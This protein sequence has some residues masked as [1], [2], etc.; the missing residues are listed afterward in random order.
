[1][2][3]YIRKSLSFGPIRFNLSN[4][5][6]GVSAGIKGFRVGSGPR[7]NYVHVGR[8]GLYYRASLPS[9]VPSSRVQPSSVPSAGNLPLMLD[10][11]SASV[12]QIVDVSSQAIVSELRDKQ[13]R[14]RLSPWIVAIGL[15][16]TLMLGANNNPKAGIA[17]AALFIAAFILAH[18]FDANRKTTVI[19]Y[20][21]EDQTGGTFKS[22]HDAFETLG[23]A[24]RLWHIPSKGGVRDAKY[25]AGANELVSRN[26]ISV[27]FDNPKFVR[28]NI[29]TPNFSVGSQRLYFFPDR[30]FI[31][32]G[33][34]IGALVYESVRTDVQPTGFI[35]TES[36]PSDS[37]KIGQ[38]WRYVN[39]KGG[40][41]RRFKDNPELPIMQ[42]EQL[43]LRSN[44]GLNELLMV[45]R[46]GT[47]NAVVVAL[48]R[49]VASRIPN[50]P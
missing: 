19:F 47:F 3:F 26:S 31:F 17:S 12:G 43:H 6:I 36:V 38:T 14:W 8:G 9:N 35:E 39:K 2:P 30:V 18:K 40:P 20:N 44:A 27:S 34:E 29:P 37:T 49:M 46:V 28:T 25:F 13:A 23:R 15:T 45:S 42:Y 50:S 41:D 16:T 48:V 33:D 11:D 1:M 4:S 5:G 22:L 7:G 32:D 24:S 21:F 10:I